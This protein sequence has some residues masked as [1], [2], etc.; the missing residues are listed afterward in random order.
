MEY[1]ED[2]LQEN[3]TLK[4]EKEELLRQVEALQKAN[5]SL[6]HNNEVLLQ[7]LSLSN[8]ARFGRLSAVSELF[9][10]LDK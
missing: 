9:V 5:T 6:L 3:E 4:K 1:M 8:K 2:I 7:A 10:D